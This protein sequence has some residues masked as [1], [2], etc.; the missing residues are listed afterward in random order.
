MC[1]LCAKSYNSYS[2]KNHT[3]KDL[4][5]VKLLSKNLHICPPRVLD[6]SN[7]HAHLHYN[8]VQDSC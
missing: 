2:A 3:I 7:V 1:S 8:I 5:F 6:I 4:E